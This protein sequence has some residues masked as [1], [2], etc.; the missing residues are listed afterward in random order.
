M[1]KIN[2][3]WGPGIFL[4]VYHLLLLVGLPFYFLYYTPSIALI[5]ISVVLFFVTGL[6]IT[7]GTHRFYAHKTY[8][9]NRVVEGIILFFATI[10]GQGSALR[11]AFEHRI[12]HAYVDTDKDPYSIKKGFWYAHMLW[13]FERPQPIEA[14]IVSDLQRNKLVLFQDKHYPLLMT[15]TNLLAFLSVGLASQRLH[16]CFFH[17]LVASPF[18]FTPLHLV[19]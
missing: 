1:D 9:V 7:A 11:W 13:L 12:H 3:N 8:K 15:L 19:H 6:C 17:R 5:C 16:G 4:I 14:R 2:F 18:C 10:A